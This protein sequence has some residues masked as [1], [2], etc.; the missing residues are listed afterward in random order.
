MGVTCAD[1]DTASP[2]R[3]LSGPQTTCARMQGHARPG[4]A[5][6]NGRVTRRR[7]LPDGRRVPGGPRADASRAALA[8]VLPPARGRG[9]GTPGQRTAPGPPRKRETLMRAISI[10]AD[11]EHLDQVMEEWL[12]HLVQAIP[13]GEHGIKFDGNLSN[14][15][16]V[17]H[18]AEGKWTV[19]FRPNPDGSRR[20]TY[21]N[22]HAVARVIIAREH[23]TDASVPARD[24]A[25]AERRDTTEA[26]VP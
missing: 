23:E 17:N 9:W 11:G 4:A 14:G 18:R 6:H 12:A 20:R 24:T 7:Y 8:S 21:T 13:V 5:R 25:A 15:A 10:Q 3:H 22:P 16:I 26:R 2:W 1:R 19:S